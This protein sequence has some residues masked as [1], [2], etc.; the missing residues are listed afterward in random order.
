MEINNLKNSIKCIYDKD[1]DEKFINLKNYIRYRNLSLKEAIE[2]TLSFANILEE[3]ESHGYIVGSINIED[4][5]INNDNKLI[6]YDLNR[7]LLKQYDDFDNYCI[8]DIAAPEVINKKN[9]DINKSTDVY[10]IGRLIEYLF[11]YNRLEIDGYLEERYSAYNINSFS[12]D[13]IVGIHDFLGKSTNLLN[14]DRYE[15]VS[16]CRE[17]LLRIVN[18]NEIRNEN[19]NVDNNIKVGFSIKTDPGISKLKLSK[20]SG[21]NLDRVNEDSLIA[22]KS[23]NDDKYFFM[24]A[25]G[26][27]NCSYGS[28]YDASNIVK[29]VCNLLWSKYE[30][31]IN[32]KDDVQKLFN[33][34]IDMSNKTIMN[35]ISKELVGVSYDEFMMSKGVMA[36]TFTAGVILNNK[37]YYI[38]LGDSPIYILS[39]NGDL[40]ILT[41]EDNIGNDTLINTKSWNEYKKLDS[42]T[43]LTKYIGGCSIDD[44]YSSDK[45]YEIEVKEIGLLNQDLLLVCTDGLTNY[46]GYELSSKGIWSVDE[47]IKNI[48]LKHKHIPLNN[49]SQMLIQLANENGGGDNISLV[50]M[51]I[52]INN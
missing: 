17:E 51:K 23:K 8:G 7:K 24:V 12:D 15:S 49:I 31:H 26:V 14:E 50:L 25:D 43:S 13:I 2:I 40:N 35:Y 44:Y 39:D 11:F 47:N 6:H 32:N 30:Q 45:K 34:I 38:N 28:G 18:I 3:I 20:S 9:Y 4:L 52:Y 29:R 21:K 10:I 37:L 19:L 5:F 48:L 33:R 27:S 46:I 42:V 36:T 41:K 1:S 16:Q 22:L